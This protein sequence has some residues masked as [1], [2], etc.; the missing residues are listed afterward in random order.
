MSQR[1][2]SPPH[3][4][5]SRGR[6]HAAATADG[7]SR[8]P[9]LRQQRGDSR[10]RDYSRSRSP[11]AAGGTDRGQ[12]PAA[13]ASPRENGSLVVTAAA[14]AAV[15]R[16]GHRSRSRSSEDSKSPAMHRSRSRSPTARRHSMGDHAG[17]VSAPWHPGTAD[18][19]P[20]PPLQQQQQASSPAQ[21]QQQ[22]RSEQQGQ[23]VSPADIGNRRSMSPQ[24]QQRQRKR[25]FSQKN[26]SNPDSDY[27]GLPSA[28]APATANGRDRSR[29]PGQ[30]ADQQE[31][32]GGHKSLGA[33]D[34]AAVGKIGRG[35]SRSPKHRQNKRSRKCHHSDQR[36]ASHGVQHQVVSDEDDTPQGTVDGDARS[37]SRSPERYQKQIRSPDHLAKRD[38]QQDWSQSSRGDH[39]DGHRS[40]RRSRHGR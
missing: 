16:R 13:A 23:E 31:E 8:S 19:S 37:Q 10:D 22:R 17:A 26:W 12:S 6:N 38:L 39:G 33:L 24:Q 40:P 7:G 30:Q 36:V 32:R 14:A 3:R 15:G 11:A 9:A 27:S 1:G 2:R 29:T 4:S 20:T 25:Q 34:A 5:R 18:R 21:H 28:A 35:C